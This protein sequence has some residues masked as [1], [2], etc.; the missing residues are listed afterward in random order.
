[1]VTSMHWGLTPYSAV[2]G[3][4]CIWGLLTVLR[5]S[6]NTHY[7][8]VSYVLHKGDK[9]THFQNCCYSAVNVELILKKRGRLFATL[10]QIKSRILCVKY[11]SVLEE[12][13][14]QFFF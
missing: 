13:I 1:M 8:T 12:P 9:K 10:H 4:Y 7:Q 6:V 11:C 3:I 5:G 14:F 2:S